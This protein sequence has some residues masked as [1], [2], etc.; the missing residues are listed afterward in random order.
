MLA[1]ETGKFESK[2]DLLE[3]GRRTHC[4]KGK[5]GGPGV[6]WKRDGPD[7]VS[8]GTAGWGHASESELLLAS[9]HFHPDGDSVPWEDGAHSGSGPAPRCPRGGEG[10]ARES[11]QGSPG[12]QA[13][14]RI[15]QGRREFS[16]KE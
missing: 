16:G 7:E 10:G 3:G 6:A 8:G 11:L 15:Y 5:A 14:A 9:I 12:L 13:D 4:S 2:N 1:T